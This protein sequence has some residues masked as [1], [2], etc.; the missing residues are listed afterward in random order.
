MNFHILTLFPE[1]VL[2]GLHTSII[3]RAAERNLIS[4]NAVNIRDYSQDK[5]NKVDDYPYGGGAGMLM[6]AQPI[7]DAYQAVKAQCSEQA[8]RTVYMTPQGTRFTQNMAK[9]LAEE[10][11]LILLCGHYEGVDERVLEEIVTDYVSIGDYVLTG[12]ELAAMVMVDAIARLVPGV[13]NNQCSAQTETFHN[14]LLEYP[15]YSRPEVWHGMRVPEI[16]LCG[17]HRKIEKWRLQCS[18]ERTARLRPDLYAVYQ[19]RQALI[20]MLCTKKRNFIHMI[21]TLRRGQ[22]QILSAKGWNILLLDENSGAC[23]LTAENKE[24]GEKLLKFVPENTTLFSTSQEF[25][26]KPICDHFGVK[27]ASCCYQACYTL[28]EPAAVKHKDIRSLKEDSLDYILEHYT[29]GDKDYLYHRLLAGVFYGA[30]VENQLVG[31]IGMHEEGSMGMLFV[32]EPFRN[33]GIGASLEAFMINKM[34]EKGYIPYCQIFSDNRASL[35]LQQKL[36]LYLSTE[37]VWWLEQ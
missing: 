24:E 11:N 14:D 21:E 27:V 30:F 28:R 2:Q 33:M 31:F 5:H 4:L 20:Q 8:I 9:E 6:Q 22:G 1:M 19:S 13:L 12:G 23:F 18:E 35:S 29:M 10:E 36:G 32:E 25:L 16:L 26:N 15:Q 3:G 37:T 17:D 34:K 7:F